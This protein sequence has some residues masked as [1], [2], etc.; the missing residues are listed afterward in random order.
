LLGGLPPGPPYQ[1]ALDNLRLVALLALG[2]AGLAWARRRL[3][4]GWAA[5]ITLLLIGELV[6]L[7]A[8]TE[9]DVSQPLSHPEQSAAL[10]FLRADPGWFRVDA[11]GQARH[12][13]SPEMLQVQGFET[14]QGSGNPFSLW[15]FEQFYWAQPSKDAPG[16]RLLGA[17]YI[18]MPKGDPPA[19]AGIWPAF[20]QDPWIDV[21]LNTLA[22]PR[23][24]LV[25]RTYP[26]S[27]YGQARH[28]IQSPAFTPE[29]MAVIENGPHLEQEGSGRIEVLRYSP[30]EV[31][32]VIHT[33]TSALL[34]LSDVYY[35]GWHA[36]VDGRSVPLYRANA[37]FRGVI[38]PAGSHQVRMRFWPA[39]LQRGLAL[40]AAALVSLVVAVVWPQRKTY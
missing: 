7:G 23:A 6:A 2:V 5:G 9:V 30:N 31:R 32:L 3:R 16:Y 11:Q 4:Q 20:T 26:V 40:A 39:S 36:E 38:V 28:F 22:L 25:Y 1:R 34:V 10:D 21:H 29:T 8:L 17:K 19:G 27:D 12:L 14:L 24:W 15:P 35:P 37:T 13:W 33:D 18:L